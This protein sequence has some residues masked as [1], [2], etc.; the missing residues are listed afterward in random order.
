[1]SN[2]G[3]RQYGGIRKQDTLHNLTIGTLVADKVLLRESY[4]GEYVINGTIEVKTDVNVYGNVNSRS[5]IHSL[6]DLF[7][8]ASILTNPLN[9]I[10]GKYF[11]W[12]LPTSP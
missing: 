11:I 5:S 4:A 9:S 3:W 1:M 2:Q 12:S 7:V 6:Y 8:G 10:G